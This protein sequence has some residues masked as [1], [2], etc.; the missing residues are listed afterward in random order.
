M[1]SL[2]ITTVLGFLLMALAWL[3]P[4]HYWP[5]VSFHSELCAAMG[6][7]LACGT[8]FVS[9]K[10]RTPWPWLALLALGMACIPLLQGALGLIFFMGDAWMAS[11]YLIG[12]ALCIV[13]GQGMVRRYSAKDILSLFWLCVVIGAVLST[14]IALAQW[15]EV[16]LIGVPMAD[17]PPFGRPFGN[18]AQPNH[19][20]TL[21][22]LGVVGS[23]A[24]REERLLGNTS[25]GLCAAF[26][27]F[28][29]TLTGSR[30]GWLEMAVLLTWLIWMQGRMVT[31]VPRAAAPLL[32]LVYAG[33]VSSFPAITQA[34]L[35]DPARSAKHLSQMGVRR[36]HWESMAD[37]VLHR[38]WL[39]YGWNQVP[40]AQAQVALDHPP[41]GGSIEHSHNIVLD[42]LVWNGAPLGLLV[43]VCLAWWF[44]TRARQCNSPAATL[45]LGGLAAVW[46]HGLLEF[47]LEFAYF[48]LPVGFMMGAT[49]GMLK[50]RTVAVWKWA[51]LALAS[52]VV[53]G[54]TWIV[55]EYVELEEA[56][57]TLRMDLAGIGR[58]DAL[59]S[60]PEVQ[61]LSQL[62]AFYAYAKTPAKKG[63]TPAE[64]THMR[65][66]AFRF[67][68]PGALI[69][70]ATAAGLNG[71]PQQAA[72]ALA[73]LCKTSL[74]KQCVEARAF[75]AEL[76]DN[77][78]PELKAVAL[79]EVP[80]LD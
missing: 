67:T 43:V 19:L 28:G 68:M 4:N 2:P 30:A 78:H 66:M 53:I 20:A 40:V 55:T 34:L 50:V 7:V 17:M 22:V 75:W 80:V 54:T 62:Q 58:E 73:L 31:V 60:V 47:P 18:M 3:M 61:L 36:I 69:R 14:G 56:G 13:A 51:T 10:G 25:F 8:Q 59:K 33:F 41:T 77:Q 15:T 39:G 23:F 57:R 16:K 9:I 44:W 32:G 45:L 52:V 27:L 38:P 63:M 6:F 21:L 64:L 26:L 12:F 71:Q 24:L 1:T 70:Y 29:L 35:L 46:I 37:A 74:P 48:L 65:N 42:L 11:L 5:W 79:P 49:D 76:A 72:A